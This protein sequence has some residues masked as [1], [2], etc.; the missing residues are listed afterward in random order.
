[1]LEIGG[2]LCIIT[3]HSL[4]D[5]IVKEKFKHAENPC[6]CPRDFPICMCGMKPKGKVITK[7]PIVATDSECIENSRAR[8]AKLRVFE[9]N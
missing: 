5:R 9:K 8:S 6:V 1:L 7:K 2:R 4:E 3:F